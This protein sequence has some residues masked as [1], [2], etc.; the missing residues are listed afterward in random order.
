MKLLTMLEDNYPVMYNDIYTSFHDKISTSIYNLQRYENFR[1]KLG[2][3]GL[4]NNK[5]CFGLCF[6]TWRRFLCRIVENL[7]HF[8][9]LAQGGQVYLPALELIGNF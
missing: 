7:M 9:N 1:I 8:K 4:A 2:E 6:S 3:C 5:Y